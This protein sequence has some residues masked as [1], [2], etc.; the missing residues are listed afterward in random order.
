M[1]D[2]EA[3]E[4]FVRAERR[5]V[6]AERSLLGVVAVFVDEAEALRHGEIDLVGGDGEFAADRAPDL[7][8]DLRAVK[9]GFV[10]HFD[11]VDAGLRCRTPR[12]MSSVLIP[13]LRFIDEFLAEL[14]RIVRARSA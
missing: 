8:V 13:E 1:L 3:D 7:D 5:A 4:T 10:R 9:G 12:T 6:N 14:G 2:Q 11:V